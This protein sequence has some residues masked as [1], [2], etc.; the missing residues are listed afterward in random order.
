MEGRRGLIEI[1]FTL[2]DF[3]SGTPGKFTVLQ[4]LIES[5]VPE[6]SPPVNLTVQS[7]TSKSV[8]FQWR[9]PRNPNGAIKIFTVL[10]YQDKTTL[11]DNENITIQ[12]SVSL[13]QATCD[14]LKRRTETTIMVR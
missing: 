4:Y 6:S 8:T 12:S 14:G 11:K 1:K 10:C 9:M 7:K 13:Y 2:L 3:C 5:S